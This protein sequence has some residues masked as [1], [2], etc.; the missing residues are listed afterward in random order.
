MYLS[1]GILLGWRLGLVGYGRRSLIGYQSCG[2][3]IIRVQRRLNGV[4]LTRNICLVRLS[5]NHLAAR[6]CIVRLSCHIRI[7]IH[8]AYLS[9]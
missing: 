7:V 6:R 2:D 3:C 8:C 5:L 4:V 1:Y 9:S